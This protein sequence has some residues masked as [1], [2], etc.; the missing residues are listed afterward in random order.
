MERFESRDAV[1]D[2]EFAMTENDW[3]AR[4]CAEHDIARAAGLALRSAPVSGTQLRRRLITPE[5]L[6]AMDAEEPRPSL[7][8]RLMKRK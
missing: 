7:L 3:E 4:S 2:L 6:A 1:F 5:I 8:H